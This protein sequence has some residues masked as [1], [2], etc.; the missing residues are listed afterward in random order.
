MI[1]MKSTSAFLQEVTIEIDHYYQGEQRQEDRASWLLGTSSTIIAILLSAILFSSTSISDLFNTF[2][3]I[4]ILFALVFLFV[5]G[6]FSLFGIIPL[7]GI[8]LSN[9]QKCFRKLNFLQIE[10]PD[11]IVVSK[12]SLKGPDEND[13]IED[14]IFHH[15]KV[16]YLRNLKKSIYVTWS[17]IFLGLGLSFLVFLAIVLVIT[18][19]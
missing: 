11:K 3:F 2:Q 5:S 13:N 19:K 10:P 1:K 7:A 18:T 17:A 8:N 4:V 14:W 15:Y 16:H 12:F 6:L 9:P